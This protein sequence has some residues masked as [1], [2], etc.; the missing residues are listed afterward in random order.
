MLI[1]AFIFGICVG[2]ITFDYVIFKQTMAR[3]KKI[4]SKPIPGTYLEW[5]TAR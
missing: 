3:L 1:L 2:K 4:A 5:L